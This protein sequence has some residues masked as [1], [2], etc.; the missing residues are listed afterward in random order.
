MRVGRQLS[1]VA[2]C[3]GLAAA[4]AAGQTNA[5]TAAAA[6]GIFTARARAPAHRR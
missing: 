4:P 1:V 6:S 3:I 5:S 2:V